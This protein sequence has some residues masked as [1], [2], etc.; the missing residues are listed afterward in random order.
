MNDPQL[1][2]AIFDFEE[3]SAELDTIPIAARRALDHAGQRMSLTS[4]R[5]LTAEDRRRLVIAGADELV[6]VARVASAV[7]RAQPPAQA[8]DPVGDPDPLVAPAPVVTAEGPARWVDPAAWSRLRSLERYA[9]SHEHRRA[10]AR[11]DATRYAHACDQLLA[12][13]HEEATGRRVAPPPEA[14]RERRSAPPEAGEQDAFG[15]YAAVTPRGLNWSEVAG[16]PLPEARTGRSV[17]PPP[18]PGRSL[19][20]QVSNVVRREGSVLPPG[21]PLAPRREPALPSPAPTPLVPPPPRHPLERPSPPPPARDGEATRAISTHVLPSG[22]VRMVDVAAKP[23]TERRAVASGSVRMKP[24]TIQ[25]ITQ[26]A[27]PKGEV[28]AT[29]RIAGIMAAKRTSELIPLCHIVALTKV[30]L[31]IAVDVQASKVDI[32]AVAEAVDRT[33]VEM[34][35]MVAVS[36]ACLTIYDMLKGVDREMVV[37]EIKLLEKSGGKSGHFLRNEG[38]P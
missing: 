20:P 9:L 17:F 19:T 8:V 31:D 27:A 13:E 37:S 14:P 22:E 11:S 26:N 6:D 24:E 1:K 29:A 36:V 16:R 28:L 4:W 5:S 7:R 3:L 10:I 34:E 25:R 33:G 18:L 23:K 38:D 12:R 21:N 30:K 35:A 32:T 15:R 2:A